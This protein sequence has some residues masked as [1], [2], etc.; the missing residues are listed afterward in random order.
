V[1]AIR[2]AG[3]AVGLRAHPH[4]PLAATELANLERRLTY[5]PPSS[6]SPVTSEQATLERR[7][8]PARQALSA[9]AQ[10]VAWAAG[11]AMTLEQAIADALGKGP[12]PTRQR[13][14]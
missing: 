14:R 13:V 12:E 5:L 1:R 4:R 10:A 3:A 9:D 7:L 6:R 11:Q 8:A 2:L